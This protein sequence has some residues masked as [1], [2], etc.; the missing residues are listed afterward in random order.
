MC[1]GPAAM[2]GFGKG[3]GDGRACGGAFELVVR[4]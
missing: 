2:Q 1:C 3:E 4:A